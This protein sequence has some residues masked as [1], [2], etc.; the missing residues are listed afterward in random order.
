[1]T[2][3]SH[4]KPTSLSYFVYKESFPFDYSREQSIIPYL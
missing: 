3:R 4:A 1:M 2:D